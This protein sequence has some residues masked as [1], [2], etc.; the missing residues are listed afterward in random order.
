MK[1][2]VMR[3]YLILISLIA[4]VNAPSF[5]QDPMEISLH[6]KM[7]SLK[8]I[9]QGKTG[10]EKVDDL[11][12]IVD[13]YQVLD[14]ADQM[15]V[16][17]ATP[18][19]RQAIDEAKRI[20]YKRGLGYANLK[21]SYCEILRA[22]I[23]FRKNKKNETRLIESI[24][25]L[26]KEVMQIGEE[27]GDNI[28]I[29][30]AYSFAGWVEKNGVIVSTE[31]AIFFIK[32]AIAS[33]EK[34]LKTSQSDGYKEMEFTFCPDCKKVELRIAWLYMDLIH[35]QKDNKE[36]EQYL[37]LAI[38]YSEKA[39]ANSEMIGKT[40]MRYGIWVGGGTTTETGLEYFKKA[41][42]H[43]QLSGNKQEE[44][45][46]ITMVASRYWY[47][48][49]LEKGFEYS[50][51]SVS[52]AEKIAKEKPA[53]LIKVELGKA[54]FWMGRY[55]D[56]AGDYE[57]ALKVT[58]KG[59]GYFSDNPWE[60]S[61]WSSLMGDIY[62]HMKNY[63]SSMYYLAAFEKDTQTQH[64]KMYLSILYIDLKQYDKA[65]PLI[66][67]V[68]KNDKQIGLIVNLG[69]E[70]TVR[71]A[72]WLGKKDYKAALNDARKGLAL[73]QQTKMNIWLANN[74]LTLSD[75]FYEMGKYDSAYYYLKQNTILKESLLN[76]QFYIRLNDYK[77]EAE[78]EKKLSQINLLNKEN[79][80][81]QQQLKQEATVRNSLIVGLIMLLL[82]G[83]FI[84]RNLT[85]KRKNA[86]EKQRL[87]NEKKQTELEMQALRAQM[88]PHFIF[89]CLSSI[90]RF[91][92]KNDNK[93]ASDYLTRFSRLIRM[94]LMNSSKKLITLE[95]ELE[96]LRLY[97]DL[98]RLRFKDAFDYSITTTNIVDAGAIFIP[99]LLLQPFCENAVWHGLMHKESK[100][101]LNVII[102]EVISE[103]EKILHCVIEDNGIGREK[104]AEFKS[105]SAENEK[106]M[107]LKITTE[108]LALLNQENN[109]STFYNIEDVLNE[110]NEVE[111]TRVKLKIRYK[112]SIEEL[113]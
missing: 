75:I 25:G 37:N 107:G 90:N 16:D 48:G 63:D 12:R 67:I 69:N 93:L 60:K 87:E 27:L 113:V 15:Q 95:D 5:S 20:G 50:K 33:F 34:S 106:S 78:E 88:N 40:Y 31:K 96:M 104:A 68:L 71:A 89:N 14:E 32:M 72:I 9:V 65:L 73:L 70:Y 47:T 3:K 61:R 103:E 4:S 36:N 97:L 58:R 57:T 98:E 46:A 43:F 35:L 77:K 84:F 10:K 45:E 64:G 66:N 80:L 51:K 1:G 52:L 8:R 76:K 53:N 54:Y 101:H 59:E 94:V 18:Y 109:F 17:S 23:Y 55:Y 6:N 38:S 92:F 26:I 7:D 85:L 28:M 62:R 112:E 2:F 22:E 44:L 108:R 79:Q 39:G 105:K 30:S 21:F 100:G 110:N 83:V 24:E 102:S 11:N 99:P 81:K 29:G 19:A 74:S 56:A 91:I 111:G 42:P 13:L 82:L 86:F 41:I 49:D